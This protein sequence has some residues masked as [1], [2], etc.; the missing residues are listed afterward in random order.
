MTLNGWFSLSF[1]A[2]LIFSLLKIVYQPCIE[3]HNILLLSWNMLKTL[4][5]HEVS[6]ISVKG[7][8]FPYF[9]G[10]CRTTHNSSMKRGMAFIL[11]LIELKNAVKFTLPFL[12]PVYHTCAKTELFTLS[13]KH[14]SLYQKLLLY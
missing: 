14:I 8:I 3:V 11:T 6:L 4:H 1:L 2:T 9:L 12:I 5:V 10:T 13:H 7:H